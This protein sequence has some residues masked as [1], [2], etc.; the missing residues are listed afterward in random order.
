MTRSRFSKALDAVLQPLGFNRNKDDWTRIRGDIAA[1]V[2]RQSSW[3]GGVT[4][5]ISLKDIRTERIYLDIFPELPAFPAQYVRIG[6]L[7]EGYDLWWETDDP[8]AP[9]NMADVVLTYALPWINRAWPLEDQAREW[10]YEEASLARPTGKGGFTQI[11]L[12]LTLHRM[13]RFNDARILFNAPISRN[14]IASFVEDFAKVR[15]HL[16]YGRGGR[17]EV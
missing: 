1:T 6:K 16:G 14:A 10:Y 5:N 8:I 9:A 7:V 13:G 3:I 12:V 2:N 15:D 17:H 4:V 11:G